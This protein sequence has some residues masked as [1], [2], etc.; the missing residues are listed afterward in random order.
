MVQPKLVPVADP[1]GPRPPGPPIFGKVNVIFFTL[2]TMSKNI[3]EIE[4]GFYSGRNPRNVWK[5]GGV[6]VCA[7]IEIVAAT[8]FCSAKARFWMISEAIMI[9]KIYARLQK[10]ASN[11]S[12]FLEGG[13]RPPDLPPALAPSALG[14]RLRPL[15]APLSKIFG[16]SLFHCQPRKNVLRCWYR[17]REGRLESKSYLI[18]DRNK[19]SNLA[20]WGSMKK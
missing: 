18:R 4:F 10:I 11:F 9:P 14:S 16:F 2:Y 17:I 1:G 3:F 13:G 19:N 7:W 8:V 5:C 12:F 15:T 20:N 6:C